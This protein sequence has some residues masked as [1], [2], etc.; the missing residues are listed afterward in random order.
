MISAHNPAQRKAKCA[1]A[2][3]C[4]QHAETVENLPFIH[5][6]GVQCSTLTQ[7]RDNDKGK[8]QNKSTPSWQNLFLHITLATLKSQLCKIYII[9]NS[10]LISPQKQH[11]D[12]YI[13]MVAL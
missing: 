6:Y 12:L 13:D 8:V 10:T 2:F 1:F 4:K 5:R 11:C 3:D 9:A 7:T